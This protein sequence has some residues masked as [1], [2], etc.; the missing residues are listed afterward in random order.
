MK[1]I[2]LLLIVISSGF[3][4]AQSTKNNH[5]VSEDKNK[6]MVINNNTGEPIVI[7]TLWTEKVIK[8]DKEWRKILGDEIYQIT[9]EMGTERPFT[10]PLNDNHDYGVY[11]CIGCNNT[12]FSSESKFNSGTGWPS[13]FDKYSTKSLGIA[14]DKS[15]G[16]VR[17]ALS[18]QRCGAH[19]GHV[20]D[21]GP[22]PTG[23]RYCIDG[24]ALKFIAIEKE[25]DPLDLKTATFAGGCFWC[26]EGVFEQVKG[27][28]DVIS[29]YSGGK[30]ANPSYE[31]VGTG[32]TG[33]AEAFEFQYDSKIINYSEL[34]K[35]FVASLDPTQVNGQGPDNGTQYRSIIFY[36]TIEEKNLA[37]SYIKELNA[38]GIYSKPIAIEVLKF[39]KF[40]KAED[41]HQ[42]F[43]K[44]NPGHPYVL[45]ES[46][47]RI[48]RT[49]DRAS[50]FFK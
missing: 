44:N 39:E 17:A 36:R 14:S 23:L 20:F 9:R 10:S 16:I 12:L 15:H 41:Y 46:I 3:N 28:K 13:F 47:P 37:E 50:T 32:S 26:E 21:D 1:G 38:S 4:C 33:H 29:G 49:R 6:D 40:W 48:K 27:V 34:L 45:Q 24:I 42:D 35:V 2:F 18:C 11:N 30:S 31:K 19:L 8:T 7:D 22:K 43:I 5:V 25:S